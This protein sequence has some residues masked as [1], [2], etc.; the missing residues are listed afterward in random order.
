MSS[1]VYTSAVTIGDNTLWVDDPSAPIG[2]PNGSVTGK[3]GDLFLSPIG[4]LGNPSVY[5]NVDLTE[6]TTWKLVFAAGTG[7]IGGAVL[8][9]T[10]FS[11]NAAI[12]NLVANGVTASDLVFATI[13]SDD[14]GA[15]LGG[16]L[17]AT[18]GTNTVDVE[19][20]NGAGLNGNGVIAVFALRP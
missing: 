4:T 19:V 18:P 6:G 3:R 2:N 9:D 13:Q 14:T 15:S 1:R 11:P 16:V 10:T 7:E 17:R 12:T 20:L 8:W 5:Q